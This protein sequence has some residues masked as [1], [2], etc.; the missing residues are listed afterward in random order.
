MKALRDPHP[1]GLWST[2]CQGAELESWTPEGREDTQAGS[3]AFHPKSWTLTKAENPLP[4][5]LGAGLPTILALESFIQA[6]LP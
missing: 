4:S 5:G 3:E 2:A 1:L 6:A